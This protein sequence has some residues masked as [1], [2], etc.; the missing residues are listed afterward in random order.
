MLEVF[1]VPK[2]QLSVK[3]PMGWATSVE[4]PKGSKIEKCKELLEEKLPV[5]KSDMTLMFGDKELKNHRTIDEYI[6]EAMP[7]S[8]KSSGNRLGVT[9]AP[10][11]VP[12]RT[13]RIRKCNIFDY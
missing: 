6:K 4:V 5:S 11:T 9:L 2:V 13:H 7:G 1:E 8:Q 12:V 10:S 3:T